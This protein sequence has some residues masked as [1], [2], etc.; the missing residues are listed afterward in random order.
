[1]LFD[2]RAKRES[3]ILIAIMTSVVIMAG[4]IKFTIS[5]GVNN[6]SVKYKMES[7]VNRILNEVND[8][9]KECRSLNFQL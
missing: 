7:S 3:I 9:Q 1:M 2:M 5:D 6:D 4:D 8:A